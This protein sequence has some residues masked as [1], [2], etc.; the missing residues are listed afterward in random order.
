MPAQTT[1]TTN[2]YFPDGAKVEVKES[3][4]SY[5]DVGAI[6]TAVTAT[7]NYDENQIETANAGKTDK[8]IKNM[9]VAGSFTLINLDPEG[10]E[11]MGGGVFTRTTTTATPTTTCDNQVISSGDWADKQVL[12]LVLVDSGVTLKASAEPTITSVTGSVDGALTEDDDYT[13]IPDVNSGSGYSIVLNLAGTTLSTVSQDITIDF[14]SV[15]PVATEVI[16]AGSSTAILSAYAMR[17][18]HTDSNNKIRRLELYAVDANSGGFQFNFKGA[19]EEGLEEMPLTYTARIDTSR[20][21]GDQLF[22]WTIE[23]GAS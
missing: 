5:F 21:D 23:D 6:Q 15:T 10:V 14:N 17:I 8:Q 7:F 3:G 4:G 1:K 22:A 12:N 2:L 18:T 20:T 19:N 11:K 16:K 9:T 13:I